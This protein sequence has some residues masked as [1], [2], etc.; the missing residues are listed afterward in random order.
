MTN[1]LNASHGK[2][3]LGW[4]RHQ[5]HTVQVLEYSNDVLNVLLQRP[6]ENNHVV[7]ISTRAM[8]ETST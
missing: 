6:A 4:V 2:L 8:G 1:E 5:P 7:N 3:R